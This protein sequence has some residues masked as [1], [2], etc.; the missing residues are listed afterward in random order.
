MP[1]LAWFVSGTCKF[2]I[3]YLQF[4]KKA[5]TLVGYGGFPSTHTTI[6]S[7]VV[8]LC[9]F[10]EGFDTSLFSL[11]LGVLLVLIIDAHDLRRKVGQQAK[12][13]NSLQKINEIKTNILLREKMGHSWLEI[14]GGILL[15]AGLA[16]I[17]SGV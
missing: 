11:G 3:N 6:I 4:G 7:S 13:L 15:G 16:F 10:N 12:I 1:F 2:C 5:R 9:G 8:F 14:I 17:I